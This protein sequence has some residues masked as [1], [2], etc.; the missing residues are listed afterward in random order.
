MEEYVLKAR[1]RAEFGTKAARRL[2][3][4]GLLPANIYG[5]KEGNLLVTL[6]RKEFRR[7]FDAGHRIV[8][9]EI[10][11]KAEQGVLK[12]VQYDG[13]GSELVHVDFARVSRFEKIELEVPLELVGTVSGGV[14][15]FPR[16]EVRIRGLP[17][18]I[19]ERIEL[20]IGHLKIGDSVR[21]RELPVPEG[22]ELLGDLETIVVAIHEPKIEEI[23]PPVEAAPTEP[24]LVGRAKAK[25]E[26]EPAEEKKGK[27]S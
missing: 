17:R 23:K 13:L 25:E 8:T 24:E 19:P 10:D 27:E 3:S 2:R 12:E 16:K 26:E 15:D 9:I 18:Q 4:Q 14:V 5:H 20:R 6:D 21:A 22:C 7:F 1:P 11:G